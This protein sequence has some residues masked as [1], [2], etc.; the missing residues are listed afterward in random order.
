MPS[1]A[2]VRLPR[3]ADR[4]LFCANAA[5][6]EYLLLELTDEQLAALTLRHSAHSSVA[7]HPLSHH[8]VG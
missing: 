6:D 2:A 3:D 4:V 7:L 5:V 1:S 8:T